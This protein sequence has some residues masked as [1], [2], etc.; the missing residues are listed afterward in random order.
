M[1]F[2]LFHTA[3]CVWLTPRFGRDTSGRIPTRCL[4]KRCDGVGRRSRAR[5]PGRFE[6]RRFRLT[7]RIATVAA[8]F[9]TLFGN[10]EGVGAQ[11]HLDPDIR[12]IDA[13]AM[14][15]R[16]EVVEQIGALANDASSVMFDRLER[17]FS[18]FL[19]D[20]LAGLAG[21]RSEQSRRAERDASYERPHEHDAGE[22]QKQAYCEKVVDPHAGTMPREGMTLRPYLCK[23]SIETIEFA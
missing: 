12:R 20:L 17:H 8:R 7:L 6:S 1:R 23:R 9:G 18:G 14:P 4:I 2:A 15:Q 21:A 13:G 16:D 3:A 10:A 22:P 5:C 19:D 11:A